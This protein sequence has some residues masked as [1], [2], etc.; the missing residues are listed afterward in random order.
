MHWDIDIDS[1]ISL[2]AYIRFIDLS[3]SS[4]NNI[5]SP[6]LH[7]QT[8]LFSINPATSSQRLLPLLVTA[9]QDPLR[10]PSTPC[11]HGSDRRE[12]HR[13]LFGTL[14]YLVQ[15][16]AAWCQYWRYASTR[17][18]L[19][20]FR[21]GRSKR[22]DLHRNNFKHTS[23]KGQTWSFTI[24]LS[25]LVGCRNVVVEV[26]FTIKCG[27]RILDRKSAY[28]ETR[29]NQAYGSHNLTIECKS[30]HDRQP[31]SINI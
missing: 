23:V 21:D 25:N 20:V 27:T 15:L 24:M 2:Q 4:R 13:Q 28:G 22:G 29:Q 11:Q 5:P 8:P 31:N 12:Q 16:A 10:S 26:M 1:Q 3:P 30:S 17:Y 18:R 14:L 19:L 6:Y 9:Y 7:R